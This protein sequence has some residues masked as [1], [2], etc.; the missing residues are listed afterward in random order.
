MKRSSEEF[1]RKLSWFA[2]TK[3]YSLL[4]LLIVVVKKKKQHVKNE[5]TA[6]HRKKEIEHREERKRENP[7]LGLSFSCFVILLILFLVF[8]VVLTHACSLFS[9]SR[10][11]SGFKTPLR[12]CPVSWG[13]RIHWLHLCRG[14]RPPPTSVLD[15][16]LNNLMVRFQQY[17]SFGECRVPLHCHSS[18]VHSGPEW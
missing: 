14:V 3:V 4:P 2:H 13:C 11:R 16:T 10:L 1:T 17:W 18:Q 12:N 6:V 7:D 5:S 9:S 8:I 15:M